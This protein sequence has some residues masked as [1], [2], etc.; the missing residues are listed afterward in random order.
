MSNAVSALTPFSMPDSGGHHSSANLAEVVDSTTTTTAGD[1]TT[2]TAAD[3]G[4]DHGGVTPTTERHPETTDSTVVPGGDS[5]EGDGN[6]TTP[7]S[8][9]HDGDHNNPESLSIECVRTAS[10]AS[11]TCTWTASTD[12]GH[13]NYVLLRTGDGS[14]RVVLNSADAL[15]F[16]DTS[17]TAGVEY[18]YRVDSLRADGSVDS[19]SRGVGVECCGGTTPTTEHHDNTTTTTEH[20]SEPTTTTTVH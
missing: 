20:H 14:G 6:G 18:E 3:K 4:D 15:T 8:E 10:P 13:A 5:H 19:H 9:H 16:T 2:T 17:V 12:P 11:I 1:V 7:T